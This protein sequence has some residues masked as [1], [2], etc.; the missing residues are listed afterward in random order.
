MATVVDA[1]GRPYTPPKRPEE[2]EIAVTGIRDKF[3]T[4]P[5]S[6]LTPERLATIFK[7][8]D[9]GDIFRQAELFGE[10]EEKDAHL[11]SILQTRRLA[12][13]G[14]NLEI[15]AASDSAEDKKIADWAREALAWIENWDESLTDLLDAI[16]KGF[17][18]SEIMWEV[19]EG[20][21]WIREVKWRHQKRFT[22]YD[23][24]TVLE[25][26]RLLTDADP[27]R[28]ELLPPN[29]FIVHKYRARAGTASR[30]GLLRPCGWMYLFKNY[31]IKDWI[32][33][34]EVYGMPLRIG[35][36][37]PGASKDDKEV[38]RQAVASLG[39]DAAGVISKATEIEFIESIK[40]AQG[41]IY[42]LLVSFCDKQMSKAVLGQTAT[43]EGTPGAL[44][45]EQARA[46]VRDD[47]KKADA[48][49]L[50]KTLR[51]QLIRPLVGFNFG[52]EKSIPN[53]VMQYEE[54]EDLQ[55][56]ATTYKT[57]VEAGFDGIP[58]SYVHEKFGIPEAKD[59]EETLEAPAAAGFTFPGAIPASGAGATGPTKKP[60]PDP[61]EI[62]TGQEINVSQ[63]TVL[64]GAQVAA[65]TAIVR[66]VT[67]GELPRNAG[68]GQL[69]VLF[70]LT[71]EQA[72]KM[73]GS[74]GLPD[75]PTTPNPKPITED[76]AVKPSNAP[77]E[78][79]D[80]SDKSKIV[81]KAG[82][83]R[84]A[85]P[86]DGWTDKAV[87]EAGEHLSD[88]LAPIRKVILSGGSLE[89]IRDGLLA[90]YPAMKPT[91]M[92]NLMQKALALSELLG[93]SE[94]KNG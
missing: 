93:R 64:N 52:W 11:G 66:S 6:G 53:V 7:E 85:D 75:I 62:P 42:E 67:I 26:P 94:V 54:E 33:F 44:G 86:L 48:K 35:R 15:T 25:Y 22:F 55:A 60:A 87:E 79:S 89:E 5:S 46:D 36:Y 47:L 58:K 30:A 81:A 24:Q 80:S 72:E 3:S 12:V 56:T 70:N 65:A 14:C 10:M 68:L 71:K 51:M 29:K 1:Y 43:T 16:G 83:R 78:K 63:A 38:L 57:L 61:E 39:T 19:A 40:N 50:A 20:K 31:G 74:A 27:V 28:G 90:A 49:S 32:V 13:T 88:W 69:E 23:P 8:A 4:Y 73:M 59:D 18:V 17:A 9:T 2:Q 77:S 76:P 84:A 21:A 37:E 82:A 92:G 34:A 45:S 41:N 91:E